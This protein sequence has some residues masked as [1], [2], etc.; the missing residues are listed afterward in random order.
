M[1]KFIIFLLIVLFQYCTTDTLWADLMIKVGIHNTEPLMFVDKKGRGNGFFADILEHIATNEGWQ[2]NYVPGTFQK[3]LSRLSNNEIDILCVIASSK[4]RDKLYD[5]NREAI[6]INWG[7]VYVPKGS[8]NKSI[9]DFKEKK[10]AVLQGDIHYTIFTQLIKQFGIQAQ[11]IETK[12]YYSVF[13]LIERGKADA[14]IVTRFF[15]MKYVDKYN[16]EQSDIIFN[17]V[18]L[19]FAAGKNK[20]QS[21]LLAIDNHIVKLKNNKDSFYYL[22]LDKWL[23]PDP[24]KFTVPAWIKWFFTSIISMGI[25]LFSGNLVLKNMIQSKTKE[26]TLKVEKLNKSGSILKESE[27]RFKALANASNEAIFFNKDGVC[28]E[29]NRPA[30]VMFGYADPLEFVG[31]TGT[32]LIAAESRGIVKDHMLK[33]LSDPYE[34]VGQRKD[35]TLFPIMIQGRTMPYKNIGEIRVTSILDITKQKQFEESLIKSEK[36]LKSIFR[37]VPTGIGVVSKRIL[38]Q[39]NNRLC[40]MTGYSEKELIGQNA[41]ILYPDEKEYEYVGNEKYRQIKSFGTGTLETCFKRKDGKIIDVLL[42]STPLD[43]DNLV[44][45]VTFTALDISEQKQNERDT[46]ALVESTVGIIGQKLFNVVVEKICEWLE[47]ECAI[48]GEID[49]DGMVI[50]TLAMLKDGKFIKDYSYKLKKSPFYETTRQCYCQYPDNV[51]ALFPYNADLIE[52]NAEGYVGASLEDQN[53]LAIGILCG[54]SRNKIDVTKHTP[55]IMKIIAARVSAEIERRKIAIEKEGLEAKLLQAQKME[56]IGTLAGGIA[57]DFNNILFPIMGYTE[58]LMEDVSVQSSFHSSLK[59]IYKG[60]LRAKD[61]VAQILT[62]S[63][64]EKNELKLMNIQPVVEESLQLIRSSISTTI[65]IN[66]DIQ[67]ECGMVK[68]DSTQIH[69]VVMNLTTNAYHAMEDTGGELKVEL[70]EI[71]LGHLDLINLE[72]TAGVYICLSVADTGRGMSKDLRQKIFDPFFT[73]KEKSKGTGMG[74]AVVH[75]IVKRMKGDIQVYSMP[76][77]GSEFRVYLP[78]VKSNILS[79]QQALK[80]HAL[81]KGEEQILLVDDEDAIIAMEQNMLERLGYKVT[82]FIS[83]KEAIEYFKNDPE[84]FDLIITDMAMPDIP[85]DKLAKELITIRSN[86]PILLCT[87]FSDVISEKK[88]KGIGIKGFLMK[89]IAMNDFSK[90]IRLMLDGEN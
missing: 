58:M 13:D 9:I 83:S 84:K 85:G 28:L 14:G 44:V 69:Q 86:I 6:L 7:Q 64:Q 79:R 77:K 74:L 8:S 61:L 63:R 45:G 49:S 46:K 23:K 1:K 25:L 43:R 70:K 38:L 48:V 11:I 51:S 12:D 47:C 30:A 59:K 24:V 60:T 57:H 76:G 31:I 5:F 4:K 40:E 41:R 88:A 36:E 82:S 20:N 3:C 19:Y 78:V 66:Q 10:I 53:G 52:M 50:N 65:K 89:P 68:A 17:P 80:N 18:K 72:L 71:E 62:F 33:N 87:G 34:A 29:A 21:L 73:T 67:S 39:V 54:I 15:G 16:I 42:S 22:S 37:V 55:Q 27:E 2:I 90:K 75:G 56:A 35:G 81:Q 32:Q 26:L